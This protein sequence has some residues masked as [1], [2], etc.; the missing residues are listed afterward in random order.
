MKS[1][2]SVKERASKARQ[3]F[4]KDAQ[5][6]FSQVN[7]ERHAKETREKAS[8]NAEKLKNY[9]TQVR[10]NYAKNPE[11][12]AYIEQKVISKWIVLGYCRA[13]NLAHY[14]IE[15]AIEEFNLK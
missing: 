14:D 8:E 15:R 13:A 6:Y 1:V 2:I 5:N 4:E 9:I 7:K 12:L 11:L 10:T 3:I